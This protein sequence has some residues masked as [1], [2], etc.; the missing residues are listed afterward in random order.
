MFPAHTGG[1]YRGAVVR[2]PGHRGDTYWKPQPMVRPQYIV[3]H[4][5]PRAT[6][7]AHADGVIIG[8]VEHHERYELRTNDDQ[9]SVHT[10]PSAT[11]KR[12]SAPVLLGRRAATL[13]RRH[14]SDVRRALPIA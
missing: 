1:A 8:S 5:G 3:W 4:E 10:A 12:S 13:T 6:W 7:T 9:V 11:R 2:S 14:G